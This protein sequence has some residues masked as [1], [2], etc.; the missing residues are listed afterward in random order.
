LKK[1]NKVQKGAKMLYNKEMRE[2]AGLTQR[3]MAN[4]AGVAVTYIS[5]LEN[6][7]RS[8]SNALDRLLCEICKHSVSSGV[9]Q[10]V[11]NGDAVNVIGDE[12]SNVP[13]EVPEHDE[14][15]LEARVKALE[16]DVSQLKTT[17]INILTR[18]GE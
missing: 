12:R 13:I 18:M 11:N 6:G 15:A 8:A 9:S 4:I 16:A 17:I 7:K 10:N 5:N 14:S 2:A 3:E 1:F